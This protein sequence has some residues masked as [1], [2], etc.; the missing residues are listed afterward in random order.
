MSPEETYSKL[1]QPLRINVPNGFYEAEKLAE[2]RKTRN[3]LLSASD[4]T[5]LPDTKLDSKLKSKWQTYRQNLRDMPT[6]F[7]YSEE[8]KWPQEPKD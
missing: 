2:L 4:W 1:H 3:Q 8:I 7:S 5:Q 6:N